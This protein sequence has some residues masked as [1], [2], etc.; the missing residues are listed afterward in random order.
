MRP[1][2]GVL[3]RTVFRHQE[4]DKLWKRLLM[5]I[6]LAGLLFCCA[7]TVWGSTIYN[8]GTPVTDPNS[9]CSSACPDIAT[10]MAVASFTLPSLSSLT[11]VEFWTLQSPNSYHGGALTWQICLDDSC[12][13][14]SILGSGNFTLSQANLGF[15]DVAGYNTTEY[16]N[17][18]STGNLTLGA[19]TYYLDIAD[20]SGVD[21][22]GIFW[23]TSNPDTLAFEL[24][25]TP[26]A[27]PEP[28]TFMLLA[29]GLAALGLKRH[30]DRR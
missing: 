28:G 9:D 18:F 27:I 14:G 1:P 12:S 2:A 13:T 29:G 17:N 5:R 4:S 10:S 24:T 15:V 16:Q 8:N 26:L 7:S 19:Q 6:L 30:A 23:A 21:S 3:S 22:F 11:G 25:G 20:H